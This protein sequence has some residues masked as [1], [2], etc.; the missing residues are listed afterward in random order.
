LSICGIGGSSRRAQ[1]HEY[2]EEISEIICQNISVRRR[3]LKY[4]CGVLEF[5]VDMI[6]IVSSGG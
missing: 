2:F 3:H 5:D 1:L 6:S 4:R